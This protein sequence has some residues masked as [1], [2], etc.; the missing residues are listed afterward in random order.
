MKRCLSL[1]V[2]ALIVFSL[3]QDDLSHAQNAPTPRYSVAFSAYDVKDTL[4][5]ATLLTDDTWQITPLPEQALLGQFDVHLVTPFWSADGRTMF[6]TLLETGVDENGEDYMIGGKLASFDVFTRELTPRLE[7]FTHATHPDI[8]YEGLQYESLSPDGRFAWIT[9]TTNFNIHYLLNLETNT[10]VAQS[11]CQVE[12]L[13]WLE[14]EV[15]VSNAAYLD[16]CDPGVY[17]LDLATGTKSRILTS[18]SLLE[19][20]WQ[21]YPTHGILLSDERVIV[22]GDEWQPAE[23]GL[24]ALDGSSGQYFGSGNYLEVFE[25]DGVA[26]WLSVEKGYV[27]LDLNT[28]EM[29]AL[30]E[31]NFDGGNAGCWA[32]VTRFHYIDENIPDNGQLTVHLITLAQGT[33]QAALLYDGPYSLET[34]QYM[35][36]PEQSILVLTD[37]QGLKVYRLG[38]LIWDSAAVFPELSPTFTAWD[39]YNGTWLHVHHTDSLASY[40]LNLQ[41]LEVISPP[42]LGLT[43]LSMSPDGAWWLYGVV[44]FNWDSETARQLIAFNPASGEQ[45]IFVDN[46][47]LAHINFHFAP[48]EYYI[49]SPII[50]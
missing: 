13:V 49:W 33:R 41:T 11:E 18:P 43:F 44:D 40:M 12:V 50:Q 8:S 25:A 14:T 15:L 6:T 16:P 17:T 1:I 36:V 20:Y 5:V 37:T 26:V 28:Q 9:Q 30:D 7:M 32:N 4:Y 23:V 31:A 10:V 47:A 2:L 24:L 35:V 42:Q 29:L 39:T 19:D 27:C 38:E 34:S 46:A 48:E 21:S 22:Y 45:V 3:W